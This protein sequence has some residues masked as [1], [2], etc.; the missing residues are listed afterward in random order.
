MENVKYAPKQLV[1][2]DYGIRHVLD[3]FV[4]CKRNVDVE[5]VKLY[6]NLE[7]NYSNIYI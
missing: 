7:I 1:L 3:A 6:L 2:N 4:P 5:H